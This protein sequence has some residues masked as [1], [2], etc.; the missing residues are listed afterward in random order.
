VLVG[1]DASGQWT[2]TY[3]LARPNALVKLIDD[4]AEGRLNASTDS[5][6]KE[7]TRQ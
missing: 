2:R 7:L 6:A 5:A 1:N 3:G 4:A